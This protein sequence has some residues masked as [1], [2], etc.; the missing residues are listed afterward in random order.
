MAWFSEFRILLFSTSHLI[1][2]LLDHEMTTMLPPT[3][4]SSYLLPATAAAVVAGLTTSAFICYRHYHQNALHFKLQVISR[5]CRSYCLQQVRIPIAVVLAKNSATADTSAYSAAADPEGLVECNIYVISGKIAKVVPYSTSEK[6]SNYTWAATITAIP[7]DGA[8]LMPCFVDAHTHLVKTHSVPRNR[9]QSGTITEAYL[10]REVHDATRHWTTPGDI[11][12]RMDFAVRSALA[13][14]T[15]ALRTHL[16]GTDQ[17]AIADTVY[18]AYDKMQ[19]KYQSVMI[20]Q[21]VANL[22]LPLWSSTDPSSQAREFA[23]RAK[24]HQ[25][26][27]LGAYCGNTADVPMEETQKHFTS[28][29]EIAREFA[30]DVDLH[31]DESNDPDCCALQPLCL[32]LEQARHNGYKRHVVLGHCCA[33]S[34]Q[35]PELQQWICRKLATLGK[36]HVIINPFTNLGLQ[37]RQVSSRPFSRPIPTA[38][39]RTP[40][41]RGLTLVQ[42]L[43]EAG[44]SV[45]C[46]SDNVRDHWYPYGDYDLLQV[47]AAGMALGHLDTAPT[48]G[49]WADLCTVAPAE[50]MGLAH[51]SCDGRIQEGRVADLIIF[52]DATR[53]SELF[54]RPHSN[55]IQLR[56]GRLC[57]FE[58]PDYRELHPHYDTSETR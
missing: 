44:V 11:S 29:F 58:L 48:E 13:H 49:A 50:A 21:G 10:Q 12:G 7:C 20:L 9:N 52:P 45:V 2:C 37:D 15:R 19:Q 23:K 41:W 8:I 34:L 38:P 17:E 36:I 33:L 1:F 42:E 30:M 18:Q 22:Y 55:R 46:A 16:D 24:Q 47:W 14:G 5:L 35:S 27:V 53:M 31:I 43:R 32:A 25:N 56:A 40:Q 39:P 26:T 54:A 6:D 51:D 28:L 57:S 4:R 3:T